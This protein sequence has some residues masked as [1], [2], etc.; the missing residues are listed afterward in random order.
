MLKTLVKSQ[1]LILLHVFLLLP[2]RKIIW[3]YEFGILGETSSISHYAVLRFLH[4]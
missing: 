3:I 4:F 1:V 2:Q